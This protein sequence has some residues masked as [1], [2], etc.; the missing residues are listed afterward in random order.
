[1][2]KLSLRDQ[3]F[4]MRKADA[5]G[6]YAKVR[7]RLSDNKRTLC[8]KRAFPPRVIFSWRLI[9]A[10]ANRAMLQG[11]PYERCYRH[12][13]RRALID[14]RLYPQHAFGRGGRS[15]IGWLRRNTENHDETREMSFHQGRL[16]EGCG[17]SLTIDRECPT[18][19]PSSATPF[20]HANRTRAER[21]KMRY[22]GWS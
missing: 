7:L 4:S 3:L 8:R 1:L 18:T 5:F 20:A 6:F 2:R 10:C 19:H 11:W 15:E 12:S 16:G 14:R 13:C 17:S 9:F 22:E 21:P